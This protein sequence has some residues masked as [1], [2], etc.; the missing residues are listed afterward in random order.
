M[1]HLLAVD[2]GTTSVKAGLFCVDG[3]CLAI[4]RQ[5]YQLDT[6]AVDRAELDP[7]I[8]WQA[9]IAT[10]RQVLKQSGVDPSQV[11][12]LGISSQG[13]TLIC[14][15]AEGHP[16]YPAIIWLDNRATHQADELASQFSELAYEMTGIPE[17]IAT[18]PACKIQW[19]R[20]NKPD[21]FKRVGKFLLVQD[22]LVHRL[23]GLFVTNASI[24]CTSL[25]FDFIHN[26]WWQPVLAAIGISDVQLP[27]LG[28]PGAVVGVLLPAAAGQLGLA[29][30]L[31]VVA[32]GMDQCSGA[33]GA[34][35]IF[36]GCCSETTGAALTIQVSVPHPDID[37]KKIIPVYAH[38]IPGQYLLV[39]VCPTAGM[40]YKWFRDVFCL[41][42]IEQ[43]AKDGLDSYDLITRL[44][45]P[46]GAGSDG[47]LLLP[48]LMGAYSPTP[49]TAARGSFTGFTLIHTRGHFAR[50]V[51]E[52]V[53]FLLKLNLDV[54]LDTGL[55]IREI[56]STGGGSRSALWNQ[57]KANV[58]N[59]PVVSLVNEDTA[60]I[61][62]AVLAGVAS[63]SFES[64]AQ[65]CQV[66][67]DLKE[68]FVPDADTQAYVESYR[69]Y[70]DLD[71]TLADYYKRNF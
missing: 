48:H 19:L 26:E 40:A 70:C 59:L 50:A 8:Y 23:T 14:V 44:A 58:C 45:A 62:D 27:M 68:R 9:C 12:S 51:L 42:E 33:I 3:R 65:G 24:A 38:S 6:P 5:E 10:V 25:Y 4:A 36:P 41:P 30:T 66:M 35:N 20:E 46:I 55:A 69:R 15:D 67:L 37:K 60:L 71:L 43:A 22:F 7:E 63:G 2:V 54:I 13:E 56:R 29:P 11:I 32:C 34:G 47:L 49:N 31:Q 18:W 64:I 57:I 17:I 61:G 1:D 39:P 53:A 52:G 28:Q 16:L 21:V